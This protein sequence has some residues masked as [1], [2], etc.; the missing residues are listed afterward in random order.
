MKGLLSCVVLLG[1]FLAIPAQAGEHYLSYR[2]QMGNSREVPAGRWCDVDLAPKPPEGIAPIQDAVSDAPFYGLLP[3]GNR[4]VVLDKSSPDAERFDLLRVD[5]NGDGFHGDNEKFRFGADSTG[6]N[7][8]LL[9][10]LLVEENGVANEQAF[11]FYSS[12]MQGPPR[13]VRPGLNYMNQG[14]WRGRATFGDKEYAVALHDTNGDGL[15]GGVKNGLDSLYVDVN[16][17]GRFDSEATAG[18]TATVGRYLLVDGKYWGLEVAS[19][20]SSL[21]ISEPTVAT[22]ILNPDETDVTLVVEGDMGVL[23]R[24]TLTRHSEEQTLALPAGDYRLASAEIRKTDA[25]GEAWTLT[26]S[27]S[28]LGQP[29]TEFQVL[30]GQSVPIKIGPPLTAVAQQYSNPNQ[31]G[32]GLRISG[33]DGLAYQVYKGT[34]KTQPPAPS[35]VI[36]AKEGGWERRFSFQYG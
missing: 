30:E 19:D 33:E 8:M 13:D 12:G 29:T 7:D 25:N 22:G 2:V 16:G 1:L 26:A 24:F 5:T 4:L 10:R 21:K 20:G 36:K 9:V 27:E 3:C 6:R 31:L 14:Y 18:E 34:H 35:L 23:G 17:D 32:F 11:K 28:S 15:Y